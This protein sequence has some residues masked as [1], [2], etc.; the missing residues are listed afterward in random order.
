M[1]RFRLVF[2]LPRGNRQK[3]LTSLKG[4]FHAISIRVFFLFN[5]TE[6][7]VNCNLFK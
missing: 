3:A 5:F 4:N 6:I 7:I 1:N 2:S